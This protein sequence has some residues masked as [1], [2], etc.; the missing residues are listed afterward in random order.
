[1]WNFK[2]QGFTILQPL[3]PVIPNSIPFFVSISWLHPWLICVS[4]IVMLILS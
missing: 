1:M 4:V 3:H 2:P